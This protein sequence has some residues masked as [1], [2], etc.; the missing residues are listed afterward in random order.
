MLCFY[1]I[2]PLFL[3][4]VTVKIQGLHSVY[5]VYGAKLPHRQEKGQ[6]M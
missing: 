1:P 6:Q 2:M 3:S 5:I 4:H